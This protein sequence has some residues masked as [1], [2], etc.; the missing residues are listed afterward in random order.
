[1]QYHYAAIKKLL[2][3]KRRPDDIVSS[4]EKLAISVYTVCNELEISILSYILGKVSP[5]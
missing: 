1:M 2:E 5:G 4:V 3:K